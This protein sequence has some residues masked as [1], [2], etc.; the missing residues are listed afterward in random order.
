MKNIISLFAVFSLVACGQNSQ[1][2]AISEENAIYQKGIAEKV[3]LW[4]VTANG[5]LNCRTDANTSAPIVFESMKVGTYLHS[6]HTTKKDPQG[7]L[8]VKVVPQSNVEHTPCYV[9]AESNYIKPFVSATGGMNKIEGDLTCQLNV[10]FSSPK[11][12]METKKFKVYICDVAETFYY[13]AF[14]KSSGSSKP[15]LVLNSPKHIAIAGDGIEFTNGSFSYMV[16]LPSSP[17]YPVGTLEVLKNDAEFQRILWE[18]ADK[19]YA[20]MPL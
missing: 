2:N 18:P 8:W 19:V 4:V 16:F 10:K 20:A 14:D 13:V 11:V 7:K 3:N 15:S 9:L 17:S 5:G 1:D 6:Q 12:Y